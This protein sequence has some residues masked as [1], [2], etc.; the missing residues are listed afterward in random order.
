MSSMPSCKFHFSTEDEFQTVLMIAAQY[1]LKLNEYARACVIKVTQE[2]I[3]FRTAEAEQAA[4]AQIPADAQ[5]D[6]QSEL[7]PTGDTNDATAEVTEGP[8]E[9]ESDPS[10][11][12]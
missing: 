3:D 1:N 5:S 11:E 9:T 8:Q 12:S 4:A 10:A 6:V 7:A 2:V